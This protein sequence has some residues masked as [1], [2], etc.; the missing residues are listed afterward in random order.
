[1]RSCFRQAVAAFRTQGRKQPAYQARRFLATPAQ[2]SGDEI[3]AAPPI[4]FDDQNADQSDDLFGDSS[5]NYRRILPRLRIV[6]ASPSYF[7]GMPS[8][9]DDLLALEALLRKYQTL[10]VLPPGHAPRIAW[11]TLAQYKTQTGEPVKAARYKK[12]VKVL[13][14]LNYIHPGLMPQEVQGALEKYK[15]DIQPFLNVPKPGYVDEY[16][17]ARGVGRRKSSHAVAYLVEGEGEVLVNGKSL[18]QVFGRVHDRE[19]AIWALKSTDRI[20]KYN[21]WVKVQGG[22]STGQADAITLA[23]SK[24]LMVHEPDLKP[25]LRRGEFLDPILLWHLLWLSS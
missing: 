14:R 4:R 8:F 17:R 15:R 7:T 9:T 25:A 12:I 2:Q 11:R 6:P 10:P 13:Q 23:V 18:T 20:D 3:R 19:S 1:M 22:G 16:G 5:T 24:A 21:V